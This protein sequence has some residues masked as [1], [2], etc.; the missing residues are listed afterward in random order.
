M[1][2]PR[3]MS[4]HG[5][6]LI[7]FDVGSVLIRCVAGWQDACRRA[8]LPPQP[9]ADG[10]TAEQ[11]ARLQA[12]SRHF[13]SGGC[14]PE[15]FAERIHPEVGYPPEQVL[16]ALQT[17]LLELY[18][19]IEG[20]LDRIHQT[21]LRTAVLSNTNPT[22]WAMIQDDDGRFAPIGRIHHHFASHLIGAC[23]PDPTV[24]EH[25][26]HQLGLAPERILFFDDRG[27]NIEAA[28]ARGWRAERIDPA[29]DTAEQIEDH[30]AQRRVL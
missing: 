4:R 2:G 18:P 12:A 30:L 11:K 10:F 26:E 7:C 21:P 13:E 6:E 1:E 20:L 15:Q 14:T 29:A 24:Y 27:E 16:A 22:H 5:I 25:V 3:A 23:K 28:I 8:A 19:G 9:E 17:W